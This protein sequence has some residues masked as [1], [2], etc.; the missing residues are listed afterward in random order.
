MLTPAESVERLLAPDTGA[1]CALRVSQDIDR[2][3]SHYLSP[4]GRF[5]I[6]QH[7]QEMQVR[8]RLGKYY[9][10]IPRVKDWDAEDASSKE[11]EVRAQNELREAFSLAVTRLVHGLNARMLANVALNTSLRTY[12]RMTAIEELGT[13]G[14]PEA[15]DALTG[16][17]TV[18]GW[19]HFSLN[20]G[21]RKEAV[22]A[23]GHAKA[24]RAVPDLLMRLQRDS[25]MAVRCAA[26]WAL[27]EI[28]DAR[29]VDALH[30]AMN[31]EDVALRLHATKALGNFPSEPNAH[32]LVAMLDDEW[33]DVQIAAMTSLAKIAPRIDKPEALIAHLM[34]QQVLKPATGAWEGQRYFVRAAAADALGALK[35]DAAVA[36]LTKMLADRQ[37]YVV[38]RAVKALAATAT[39]VA[40]D[41]LAVFFAKGGCR[42]FYDADVRQAMLIAA[43]AIGAGGGVPKLVA[44]LGDGSKREL[45][46][47]IREALAS[48]PENIA[49]TA[50]IKSLKDPNKEV[51]V[52]AAGVL[53]K[54]KDG[55][56]E[57]ALIESLK[58]PSW[59]VRRAA[60]LALGAVGGARARRALIHIRD[61][62]ERAMAVKDAA[63]KAIAILTTQEKG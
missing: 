10:V 50:L 59:E 36:P 62:G 1:S 61:N 4:R 63:C 18:Y 39:P 40:L 37:G 33:N 13:Q 3:Q 60:V 5:K 9:R 56:T 54:F 15:K 38:M 55:R 57:L 42:R 44:M 31:S 8:R 53:G 47:I 17:I 35:H 34:S 23:L 2:C 14:T 25:S 16:M 12:A 24:R 58:D 20:E 41:S 48:S 28:R 19:A 49:R 45:H 32:V 21:L 27:G 43:R 51:R 30:E 6:F 46:G 52:A 11:A 22:V 7:Y 26:A 29:A